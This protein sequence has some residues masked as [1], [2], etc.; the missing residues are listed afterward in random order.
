MADALEQTEKLHKLA[1]DAKN[2]WSFQ[3]GDTTR[4]YPRMLAT[5]ATIVRERRLSPNMPTP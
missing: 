4:Y 5:V 2:H 3:R 1:F